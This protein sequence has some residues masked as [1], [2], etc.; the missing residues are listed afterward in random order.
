[1]KK[2]YR[3]NA[4]IKKRM[5][6]IIIFLISVFFILTCRLSYIMIF[7]GKKLSD[8][9][10]EQ[11]T[12]EVKIDARRGKIVDRN[13]VELAVSANV[14]RIDFDLNS[15]RNYLAKNELTNED[16]SPKIAEA[17]DI[18]KE[19]VLK[20][21]NTKLPSGAAAGSANLV[22]RIEKEYVDKVKDLKISGV[23]VSPDT[24]RYYPN[25]N[26]LSHVL[27][28]T[29]VDGKGLT[30]IELQYNDILS[31]K[32]GVRIA[33]LG[34]NSEEL[35]Y[36]IT[37]FTPPVDGKDIVLTIDEKIQLFAE[38]A[39]SIALN[40][41]KAK[42]VN[43]T[44]MNPENGEV[45]AMASKPDFNP[46]NPYDGAEN[47]E[48][49][50]S[51]DKL[52][53]MWRNKVVNDTFECG[54]IFKIIT[55]IA[56]MEENAGDKGEKYNCSGST[57]VLNRRIKC[58][59]SGGHGEQEFV[60][61]LKN[62]CNVGFIELSR[63]LGKEKLNEYI[64]KFGFGKK[65][66]VDL[67]GE[68]KGIIKATK[69]ITE[70]D[71]ATIGFGQT[72]T[73]NS[74][75]FLSAFNAIANN[76][77]WIKPHIMKEVTS[78]DEGGDR[79]VEKKFEAETREVV[80]KEKSEK[81][82]GYLEKVVSEG[83]G[84]RAYI[85]GYEIAG[86]TGT[87]Q[88]VNPNSGTYEPGKYMSSFVGMA[89]ASDPKVSIMITIDE[90]SNGAYY[91]GQITTPI[92][93]ML[94]NDIF[95]YLD[96]S[97]FPKKSQELIDRTAII[98]EVRGLEIAEAKK[99]LDKAGLKYDIEGSS[100]IITEISPKPGYSVK[101]DTKINLYSDETSNYNKEVVVPSLA[102]YTKEA[103]LKLL[104]S[105]GLKVG[106]DGEGVVSEQNIPAGEL[107]TK[108]TVIKC[109]LNEDL[110]D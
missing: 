33:E 80:S 52:Q 88:K 82:R 14:Y 17:T 38:K 101:A 90:P 27:G 66:G 56:A 104:D 103:A 95:N 93:N 62:S 63:S 54:S 64:K 31:G 26:F 79:K 41:N 108:G 61:I 44:V 42:S 83:S 57:V 68:A 9:A 87:A 8:K 107:V 28:S 97:L 105:L 22:R 59:K 106:F 18:N 100:K 30:G 20:K 98:P 110:G 40:D 71:L 7:K 92:A 24:K 19:E 29:N 39:A 109:K 65:T 74:I 75:Q 77:V 89:P 43:V 10:V 94:F 6:S 5:W 55:S 15:I 60:D 37:S 58:W 73:V 23:M 48:G 70:V 3:D 46:N 102:G 47:F 36:T 53:K 35:P 1:M 2:D 99:I 78:L 69:D 16:I 91:A 76:G 84:K 67:P 21:L 34:R 49:N 96:P 25:N 50:T 11:W 45:I 4:T 86:K 13:G 32:P 51:M 85:E 72:D 81:L 12:S